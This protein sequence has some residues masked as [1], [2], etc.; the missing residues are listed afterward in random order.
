MNFNPFKGNTQGSYDSST[1]RYT[2]PIAGHYI[3][4]AKSYK[5]VPTGRFEWQEN[6][7]RKWYEFW[8]P[9][10][11]YKEIYDTIQVDDGTQLVFANQGE[12]IG[13]KIEMIRIGN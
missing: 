9:K 1:G 3:V 6:Y 2:A 7:A 10:L 12:T 5:C 4:S 8:V 11:V 13:T